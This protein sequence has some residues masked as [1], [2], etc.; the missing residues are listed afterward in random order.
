MSLASSHRAGAEAEG[1]TGARKTDQQNWPLP[2][3]SGLS[4][5]ED[6]L[7]DAELLDRIRAAHGGIDQAVDPYG[8]TAAS[9]FDL[10]HG[11][12]PLPCPEYQV[13]ANRLVGRAIP[14]FKKLLRT[15]EIKRE[16]LNRR[17]PSGLTSDDYLRLHTSMSARDALA[18]GVV[19][20]G[21]DYFR[22]SVIPN[23]K[24]RADAGA[25]LE[26]YFING[27]LHHFTS[28]VKE[29]KREHPEWTGKLIY[30]HWPGDSPTDSRDITASDLICTVE[31]RDLIRRLMTRASPLTRAIMALMLQGYS[32]SEIGERLSLSARAIEGKLY[33]FRTELKR[34][35]RYGR[36][37]IPPG[38]LARGKAA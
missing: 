29:W 10:A 35:A 19:I 37:E 3:V 22:R 8:P 15:G 16:L 28:A 9:C 18:I 26:T 1:S 38:L 12:A 25:S 17:L 4:K 30:D 27:C 31:D 6:R 33:R 23:G 11:A 7:R 32:F 36:L 24:W 21:E 13:L 34:D 20:A 2:S 14:L 5:E